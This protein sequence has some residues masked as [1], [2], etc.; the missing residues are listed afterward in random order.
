MQF[1]GFAMSTQGTRINDATLVNEAILLS[2]SRLCRIV[3]TWLA[4]VALIA[5]G[6]SLLFPEVLGGTAVIN[7]NLRGTAFV[8]LLV[9][10]PL[11]VLGMRATQAGSARGLAVWLGAVAYLTYQGVMFCFAT[12]FNALFLSYVALLGLGVWSLVAIVAHVEHGAVAARVG[13]GTPYRAVAAAL[14]VFAVL[15]ATGWLARSIPAMVTGD[16]A[17]GIAGSG[18]I[19]SPVWVQDLA[20]W[21]PAAVT[22]ATMM[23]RRRPLGVLLADAMVVFYVVECLSVASDQW[24]GARADSSQPG[25]ASMAAV[26]GALA[27]TALTAVPLVWA[28]HHLD[29][30]PTTQQR[31]DT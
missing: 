7:G 15:N 23:W 9:G 29:S 4:A 18:L 13:A 11:L 2:G 26:P 8:M 24:W 16:P 28:F 10:L 17:H 19:T 31:S 21:V 3:S 20:I 22:A 25:L 27:V 12:P 30:P 14:A 5:A 1:E 6:G